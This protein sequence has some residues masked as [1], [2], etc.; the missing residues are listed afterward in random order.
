M[1]KRVYHHYTK[2][3][4]Y[5]SGMYNHPAPKDPES[6]RRINGAAQCLSDESICLEHMRRVV[7]QWPIATEQV[8]T[9]RGVNRKAWLGWCACFMYCGSHD[10]ETRK[11]WN[12][13][14][15]ETRARANAIADKVIKEWEERYE[16]TA[17]N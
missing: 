4:D 12:L 2:W 11:A 8:L 1:I 15:D 14:V 9:D 13:L 10:E 5:K 3:E 16:N 7:E 6:E 17:G